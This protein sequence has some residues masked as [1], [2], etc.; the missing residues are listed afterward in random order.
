MKAM[1]FV[2]SDKIGHR[3]EELEQTQAQKIEIEIL[4]QKRS[5]SKGFR[6]E[7]RGFSDGKRRRRVV[8][9]LDELESPELGHSFA[10][11]KNRCE[12]E[13]Q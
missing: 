3:V 9:R 2:D 8:A 1:A 13:T 12:N 6:Q 11:L 10:E 4:L 7:N 5:Q